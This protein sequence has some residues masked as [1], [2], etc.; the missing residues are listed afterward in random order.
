[1]GFHTLEIAVFL[2]GSVGNELP[3]TDLAVAE[4]SDL[5][6]GQVLS[7]VLAAMGLVTLTA[8]VVAI[9]QLHG[10][11]WDHFVAIPASF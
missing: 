11:L 1:V 9:L 4:G 10:V 8:S 7:I 5:T 2:G 6:V 3:A